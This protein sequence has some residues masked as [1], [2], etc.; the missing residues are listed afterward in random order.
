MRAASDR[1]YT[2]LFFSH[3]VASSYN[4]TLR[5]SIHPRGVILP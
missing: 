2:V 3:A 1:G 5:H 4:A